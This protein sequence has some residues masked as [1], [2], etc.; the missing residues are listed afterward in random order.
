MGPLLGMA[1]SQFA[2]KGLGSLFGDDGGDFQQIDLDEIRGFQAPTQGLIDEQLGLSRQLMDPQS[3]INIQ[4]RNMMAQ[5]ASESGAQVGQQA[6]KLGA[7]RNMSPA[8]TMMQARMGTNQAMGGVNQQ[9]LQNLQNQFSKGT[10]LM[11]SMTQ[12]QQ[13]MDEN[14]ANAYVGN[15]NA[16]NV[17]QGQQTSA[18][19]IFSGMAQSGNIN[20]PEWG[21]QAAGGND[22]T[23]WQNLGGLFGFGGSV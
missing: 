4:M 18:M 10:G 14:L 1:I 5:R 19:D 16:A 21:S 15:I 12:M 23:F 7:M 17:Q 22:P 9:W 6:M 8:Q 11:G 3:A 2:S 13:G 20:M